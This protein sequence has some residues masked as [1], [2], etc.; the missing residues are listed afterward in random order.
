MGVDESKETT[1]WQC[2]GCGHLITSEQQRVKVVDFQCSGCGRHKWST[3]RSV[4]ILG[5][6]EEGREI[7]KG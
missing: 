6:G 7:G 3:F 2:P 5:T 1:H 4:H